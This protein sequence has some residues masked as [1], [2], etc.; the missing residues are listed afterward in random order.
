MTAPTVV[1]EKIITAHSSV[2]AAGTSRVLTLSRI[3]EI[4][5]LKFDELVFMLDVTTALA[6][7]SPAMELHGA[8]PLIPDAD[9]DTVAEWDGMFSFDQTTPAIA[10]EAFRLPWAQVLHELTLASA[11]YTPGLVPAGTVRTG[12]W[13]DVITIWEEIAGTTITQVAIY[14][15]YVTGIIY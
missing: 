12:K 10:Q 13:E 8:R 15:L 5:L 14:D 1:R 4:P 2:A 7:T 6:A 9:E 3:Q 11:G